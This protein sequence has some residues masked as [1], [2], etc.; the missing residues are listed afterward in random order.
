MALIRPGCFFVVICM[1]LK[2]DS[3][4][5]SAP[6]SC[7]GAVLSDA[8]EACPTNEVVND[9][10]E[11]QDSA[12]MIQ[13]AQPILSH[14]TVPEAPGATG[15]SEALVDSGNS[16]SNRDSADKGEDVV[17]GS[18]HFC[19]N[20]GKSFDTAAAAKDYF[21][22]Q[23]AQRYGYE[24]ALCGG[25][26]DKVF[27]KFN[28]DNSALWQPDVDVCAEINSLL[29]ADAARRLELDLDEVVAPPPTSPP[30][31]MLERSAR[32]HSGSSSTVDQTLLGEEVVGRH[33][34]GSAK[35]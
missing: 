12:S 3:S 21:K 33:G 10:G 5:A 31:A 28:G 25:L 6:S 22:T 2:V 19:I 30:S 20:D 9:A 4:S 18:N 15:T 8:T 35:R 32:S 7:P 11:A 1:A 27:E 17:A 16:G 29:S 26:A 23:C 34:K 13:L 24:A 14:T